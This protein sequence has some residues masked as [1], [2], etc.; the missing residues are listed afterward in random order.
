MVSKLDETPRANRLHI[1]FFGKTN[2]GKSSVINAMTGQEV[3][4]VS[5]VARTSTD[6]VYK[7][8]E[9]LP[10]GPVVFIDTAGLDDTTELGQARIRK[11]DEVLDKVDIAVFVINR[12]DQDLTIEKEYIKRLKQK[13]TPVL[14]AY[15]IFGDQSNEDN[16]SLGENEVIVNA[17][18]GEGINEL[19]KMIVRHTSDYEL[20]TIVGDLVEA[21]DVVLLVMPQDIQAPKGRLILPQVQVIRDLLDCGCRVA[22]VKTED[23]VPM[24]GELKNPPKLVITD[25]QVFSFVNEHLSKE[26]PLTSFSMLMAKYKGDINELV[27]GARAI[28]ELKPGD[29]VLI[30]ESCTHH[31]LKGDIAREKLPA[32]LN[33]YVGGE[34]EFTNSAGHG[35]SSSIKEYKLIIHCGACMINR[36]NMLSKIERAKQENVPITNFGVAIAFLNG[37]LERVTW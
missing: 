7:A 34:L 37:M 10:I 6:P 9:L 36:K 13:N 3:A 21:G 31:A 19:K 25:S 18:T 23:L 4:L 2:A 5:D 16:P 11:T 32:W 20:P 17:K 26:I 24:L 28:A 8:M 22:C 27:A 29:K 12:E 1:A 15:N 14:I 33:R 35:F 30:A